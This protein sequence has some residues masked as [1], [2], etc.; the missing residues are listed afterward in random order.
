M[1]I[2]A[3]SKAL[4]GRPN[5]YIRAFVRRRRIHA[6]TTLAGRRNLYIRA[7]VYRRR[8]HAR[9]KALARSPNSYIRAFVHRRRIR[10]S[11]HQ[12]LFITTEKKMEKMVDRFQFSLILQPEPL[13]FHHR[14]I[15]LLQ[16]LL[17]MI[18]QG[19]QLESIH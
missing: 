19:K 16:N 8:I 17:F 6:R 12:W 10:N 14:L 18:F 2:H 13:P 15:L 1:R 11:L 3:C 7:F 4:A 5:S 9:T